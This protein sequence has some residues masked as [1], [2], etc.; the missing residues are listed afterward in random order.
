MLE[1]DEAEHAIPEQWRPTFRRIVDAF[2]AGDFQLREHRLADVAPVDAATAEHIAGNVAAYGE[3]L[4]PLDDA[5]WESSVYCWQDG[6]WEMLVD[7]TTV[8]SR[9]SDL[10]L[11]ARIRAGDGARLEIGSVH[12]P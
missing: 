1:K 12:V 10:T 3:A 7:L 11:H 9:V 8:S 6:Y 5:T 4:A 2:A